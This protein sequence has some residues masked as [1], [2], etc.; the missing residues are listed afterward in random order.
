RFRTHARRGDVSRAP[1]E[2]VS[3]RTEG[4]GLHVVRVPAEPGAAKRAVSRVRTRLPEPAEILLPFVGDALAL[5]RGGQ[6]VPAEL[7]VLA[8]P[9]R[10]PDVHEATDAR[11]P[12]E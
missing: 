11:S 7:G 8:R 3:C 4:D 9:R 1:G 10:G 5:E 6:G 12:Q 2:P